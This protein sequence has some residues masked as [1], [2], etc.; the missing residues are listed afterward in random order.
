MVVGSK[1]LIAAFARIAY[2]GRLPMLPLTNWNNWCRRGHLSN[3]EIQSM[4]HNGNASPFSPSL[5]EKVVCA[6]C[7]ELLSTESSS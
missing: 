5:R 2:P 4:T 7:Q 3:Y 6:I 1:D